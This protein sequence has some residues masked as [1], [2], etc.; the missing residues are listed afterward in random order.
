MIGDKTTPRVSPV[1]RLVV[2]SIPVSF[3]QSGGRKQIVVPA[4]AAEWRPRTPRI[5]SSLVNA[6]A[7][8]HRW[9][10][11]I[12]SQRYASAAELSRKES[13]NESYVCRLLRLTLLAPDIV[14]AVLDGRQ[15]STLELKDLTK[16]L[17]TCW[18][19]QRKHLGFN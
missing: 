5:D 11:M 14:Q 19:E 16:P 6:I 3:Q 18:A 12:E 4:G 9:R 8:A 13:V 2:V 15:P 17:P 7:R 1:G 10:H